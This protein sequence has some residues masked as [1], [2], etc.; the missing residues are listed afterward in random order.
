MNLVS[1]TLNFFTGRSC[2][3]MPSCACTTLC[4][5]SRVQALTALVRAVFSDML[6]RLLLNS[7][8][9]EVSFLFV[10]PLWLSFSRRSTRHSPTWLA[11]GLLEVH[12]C[13]RLL[14]F[15]CSFP[16]FSFLVLACFGVSFPSFLAS[17]FSTSLAFV[18]C[19]ACGRLFAVGEVCQVA[20]PEIARR[21]SLPAV[22]QV[23]RQSI[24]YHH[25]IPRVCLWKA[26]IKLSVAAF[27]NVCAPIRTQG[28]KY[29]ARCAISA[30]ALPK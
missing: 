11:T 10:L 25:A 3:L 4:L 18:C 12:L 27:D 16:P 22:L 28:S 7:P 13:S 2:L 20:G 21:L 17:A 19:C 15:F 30:A 9:Q 8:V 1:A 6:G 14:I 5:W 26:A 23:C 24:L 29:T